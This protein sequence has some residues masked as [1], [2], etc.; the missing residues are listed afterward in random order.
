MGFV[1]VCLLV[2]CCVFVG[3]WVVGVVGVVGVVVGCCV[4]SSVAC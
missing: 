1:V 4:L 3:V 2:V